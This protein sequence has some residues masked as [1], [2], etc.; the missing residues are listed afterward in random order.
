VSL[1]IIPSR[2]MLAHE[3]AALESGGLAGGT[4]WVP[5]SLQDL[6]ST[7]DVGRWGGIRKGVAAVT[8]L[9]PMIGGGWV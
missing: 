9:D 4:W 8:A 3:E 7:P 5:V 6:P 2:T 1:A